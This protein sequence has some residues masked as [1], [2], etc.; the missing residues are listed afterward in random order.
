M[1]PGA[2]M[3]CSGSAVSSAEPAVAVVDSRAYL[4]RQWKCGAV[5][6]CWLAAAVHHGPPLP[7]TFQH[8]ICPHI[9][10]PYSQ[11]RADFTL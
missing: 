4:A 5:V 3:Q 6:C 10:S 8:S 7:A 11:E 2:V 1:G 9:A